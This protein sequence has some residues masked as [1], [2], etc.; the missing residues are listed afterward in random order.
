M[1]IPRVLPLIVLP[2]ILAAKTDL[3]QQVRPADRSL[4]RESLER[5]TR[6]QIKRNWSDL[7]EIKILGYPIRTDYD[8]LS[9]KAPAPSQKEFVEEMERSV[10]DGSLPVMPSFDLVSIAPVKGGYEVRGCSAAQSERFHFK[11]IV[12]LNANLSAGQVQPR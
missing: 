1:G 2:F 10:S 9:G 8:D 12:T 7:F 6:D 11:G 5:Y 3:Y 4:L